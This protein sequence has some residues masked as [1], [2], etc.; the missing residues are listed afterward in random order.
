[1]PNIVSY[2]KERSALLCLQG[3][4]T[5][6]SGN[7]ILV[8]LITAVQHT[9]YALVKQDGAVPTRIRKLC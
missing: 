3:A 9:V 1:M 5:K 8:E 7:K 6:L 4:E 2:R